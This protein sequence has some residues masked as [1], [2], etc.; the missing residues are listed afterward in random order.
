V[1]SRGLEG[2]VEGEL[3]SGPL[4]LFAFQHPWFLGVLGI[5]PNQLRTLLKE[6]GHDCREEALLD[7]SRTLFFSGYNIWK[8]RQILNSK[9]WKEIAP[10]NRKHKSSNRKKRKVD[11]VASQSKC[12]NPFHFLA[13]HSN[14]HNNALQ[15][16]IAEICHIKKFIK[17]NPSQLSSQCFQK[18]FTMTN[19]GQ[20]HW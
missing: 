20:N 4:N 2:E 18:L 17:R 1:P 8:K 16:V 12:K 14:F 5:L 15:N 11:E 6:S 19:L 9:F 3:A 13:R 10:E 7:I